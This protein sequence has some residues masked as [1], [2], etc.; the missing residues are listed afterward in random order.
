MRI[1]AVTVCYN[2][3]D[4]LAATLPE[5]MEQID[6]L[7]VVT[8]PSDV[9]T[10]RLCDKYSIDFIETEVMHDYGDKFNK[11][12]AIN[13]G[14]MHLRHDGWLLHLDADILLP[15]R[16]RNLLE[17]ARLEV[18]NLYGAD[19]LNVEN[20]ENWVKHKNDRVPHHHYRYLVPF[21]KAF[22][23]G[24]RLLHKEFGY[25][26]IG[27][28]QLWHSS[29]KRKY[30]VVAGSA[31]HSDVVFACQWPRNKR[32]LLPEVTCIHLETTSDMGVNWCGRK[33]PPWG[34]VPYCKP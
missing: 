4:F 2:Y 7:I 30:P 1:E 31:E 22:P 21:I 29:Q 25:C 5:N 20:Y 34:P 27:Y 6:R 32:V 12:R 33:S 10:K 23:V 26:P 11:G 28:F 18:G 24:A 3:G 16:F 13:M 17:H 15:H 14:L 9:A 19:R 8:H